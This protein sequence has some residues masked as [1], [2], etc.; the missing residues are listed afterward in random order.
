MKYLC[1]YVTQEEYDELFESVESMPYEVLDR[2]L[3]F[4]E[5]H[6]ECGQVVFTNFVGALS[7]HARTTHGNITV[8]SCGLNINVLVKESD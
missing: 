7:G 6:D 5:L 1:T 4:K 3:D 8:W 2:A